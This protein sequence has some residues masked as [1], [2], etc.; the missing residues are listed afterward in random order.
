M[1][2][3]N[4]LCCTLSPCL[5]WPEFPVQ[6]RLR[7]LPLGDLVLLT[8]FTLILCLQAEVCSARSHTLFF[9]G[10]FPKPVMIFLFRTN[11]F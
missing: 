6:F 10:S 7:I 9:F 5:F 2:N 8:I 11:A 1:G 4:N 3:I